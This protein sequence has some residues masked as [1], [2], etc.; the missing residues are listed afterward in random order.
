MPRYQTFSE[1]ISAMRD[2]GFINTFS[3]QHNE[4]FCSE[5]DKAIPPEQLTL[6]EQH[7]VASSGTSPEK[8]EIFGF[9]T[10]DN[11]LGLMTSTYAAYDPEGFQAVFNRCRRSNSPHS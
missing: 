6:V 4:L 5:L 8:C 2:R 10:D 7:Q 1:A 3:I 11:A 9:R